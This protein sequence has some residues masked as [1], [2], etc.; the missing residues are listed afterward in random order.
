MDWQI[1]LKASDAV[2]T[3]GSTSIFPPFSAHLKIH[4]EKHTDS[5]KYSTLTIGNFRVR[6]IRN[7]LQ[8][9]WHPN[10]TRLNREV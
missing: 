9:H 6:V 7:I 5:R 10:E 3:K 8:F 2:A 1:G 4:I